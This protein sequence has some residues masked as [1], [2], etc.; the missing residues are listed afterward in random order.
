MHVKG[1]YMFGIGEILKS[2]SYKVQ[3]LWSSSMV[4]PYFGV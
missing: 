3:T 4:F 1:E 2:D